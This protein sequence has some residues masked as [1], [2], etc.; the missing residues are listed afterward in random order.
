MTCRHG[1]I[2]RHY[3]LPENGFWCDGGVDPDEFTSWQDF[4]DR[5]A[6]PLVEAD[7]D[8]DRERAAMEL[9]QKASPYFISVAM[10]MMDNRLKGG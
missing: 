2:D 8:E 1:H 10:V 3:T 9:Y 7:G 6:R 5:V 4:V